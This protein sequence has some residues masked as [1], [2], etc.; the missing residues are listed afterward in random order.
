MR[1][2]PSERVLRGPS[3]GPQ[4]LVS[5]RESPEGEGSTHR[6]PS[7]GLKRVPRLESSERVHTRRVPGRSPEG[8][9]GAPRVPEGGVCQSVGGAGLSKCGPP[10]H[11]HC[12]FAPCFCRGRERQR[13]N[14]SEFRSRRPPSFTHFLGVASPAFFFRRCRLSQVLGRKCLQLARHQRSWER[15]AL[16]RTGTTRLAWLPQRDPEAPRQLRLSSEQ[17][18]T[19]LRDTPQTQLETPVKQSLGA[20][21]PLT[22]RD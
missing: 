16:T 7:E 20:L 6:G 4:R 12:L 11:G 22:D 14:G 8:R 13:K 15:P 18:W 5:L 9:P 19:R 17:A 10:Y 1:R 3:G 21:A 2:V